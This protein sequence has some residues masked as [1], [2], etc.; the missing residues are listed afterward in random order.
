MRLRCY[1]LK[2]VEDDLSE[3]YLKNFLVSK[4]KNDIYYLNLK[5][6]DYKYGV[7]KNSYLHD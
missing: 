5:E 7:I 2:T 3:C 4:S 6:T 1:L